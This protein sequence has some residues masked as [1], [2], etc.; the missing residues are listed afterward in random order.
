MRVQAP[1]ATPGKGLPGIS[2]MAIMRISRNN[3][4]GGPSCP[5]FLGER[6]LRRR[7]Q[8]PPAAPLS[9]RTAEPPNRRTAAQPS[10]LEHDTAIDTTPAPG[11]A[12]GIERTVTGL[13]YELVEVERA[14]RGLLRVTIDRVPGRVY[15]APGAAPAG[16][17]GDTA[18]AGDSGGFVTV[19][20]CERVTR[21]LQYALEVDGVPYERLEVSSPGL[22]RLLRR[23]ADF[24]RFAGLEVSLTLKQP[25][26]G[27]KHWKGRLVAQEPAAG[28]AWRLVL[29][30]GKG[31]QA[32]DFRLDEVREV[33]L[34]PVVD[35]KGRG[36][37][38]RGAAADAAPGKGGAVAAPAD[39][40]L[41]R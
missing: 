18:A 28:G 5:F 11:W 13:G 2:R 26:Q 27:R 4:L 1:K 38:N 14:P 39:G 35:F 17:P 33:R 16:E 32:L 25:F 30:D 20:D 12:R 10:N 8:K 19:D 21:Q 23:E 40:G 7:L 3:S 36:R 22:D 9:R 15:A 6:D 34:V 31:E 37:H 24:H 41:E 29:S